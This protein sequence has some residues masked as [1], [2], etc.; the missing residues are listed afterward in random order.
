VAD[1]RREF[2]SSLTSR[3]AHPP[4]AAARPLSSAFL[5]TTTAVMAAITI[6]YE[7]D[8]EEVVKLKKLILEQG[9]VDYVLPLICYVL[10]FSLSQ[11][12][13]TTPR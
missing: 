5:C 10:N 2:N 1:N 12:T 13:S 7:H 9:L 11:Q 4:R 6:D 3:Q 8:S